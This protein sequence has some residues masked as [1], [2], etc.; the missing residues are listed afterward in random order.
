MNLS[1]ISLHACYSYSYC[2]CMCC[3]ESAAWLKQRSCCADLKYLQ[4][5]PVTTWMLVLTS[6]EALFP[7]IKTPLVKLARLCTNP[8]VCMILHLLVRHLHES[9]FIHCSV[10]S[11]V[12]CLKQSNALWRR[13]SL[14]QL[15]HRE[16]RL[17]GD[18][19][20]PLGIAIGGWGKPSHGGSSSLLVEPHCLLNS[21]RSGGHINKDHNEQHQYSQCRQDYCAHLLPGFLHGLLT[22]LLV[23]GCF[24]LRFA[25]Q[26]PHYVRVT[27]QSV[28]SLR[29]QEP[30]RRHNTPLGVGF[31]V[32]L[33]TTEPQP[34]ENRLVMFA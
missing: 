12:S 33:W 24:F 20:Y 5:H 8:L 6:V 16:R 23:L 15:T 4:Q 32:V 18:G 11:F 25:F 7:F 14:R 26:L 9:I 29:S 2:R 10:C 13:F 27:A 19:G 28:S 30:E 21:T 22:L 1:K 3:P 17:L 31:Q 34:P